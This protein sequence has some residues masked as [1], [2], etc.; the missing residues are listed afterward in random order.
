[1][2]VEAINSGRLDGVVLTEHDVLWPEEE[3]HALNG[4]LHRGKIYRG[5]EVSSCNG[6]FVLIGV[7][8]LHPLCPGDPIEAVLLVAKAQ[9]A[10]VIWVHPHQRYRQ[11]THPLDEAIGDASGE[12]FKE[13]RMPSRIDAIEVASTVT[14][15]RNCLR[16][17]RLAKRLGLSMVGGSDA[18]SAAALG[19]ALTRFTHLPA[20]E[21]ALAAAIRLGRCEPFVADSSQATVA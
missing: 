16:A 11:I 1:M 10:A 3:V 6:H 2:V 15:D 21:G 9:G 5:V 12:G 17:R 4:K 13:N 20:D 14:K 19:Q 18:H 8:N 7:E